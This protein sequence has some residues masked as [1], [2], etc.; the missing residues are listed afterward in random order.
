MNQAEIKTMVA[1]HE[2]GHAYAAYVLQIP[3]KSI[4]LH[5]QDGPGDFGS[6]V[7]NPG[8]AFSI[9]EGNLAERERAEKLIICLLSGPAAEAKY[10]GASPWLGGGTDLPQA[11]QLACRR[12]A[13]GT[14]L[15]LKREIERLWQCARD[16]ICS[17]EGWECV[18]RLATVLEQFGTLDA[19]LCGR[20][21]R[22]WQ[23]QLRNK[24]QHTEVTKIMDENDY[25]RIESD[26]AATF[27]R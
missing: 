11:I 8:E 19:V 2:A 23:K 14:E 7:L 13:Y 10:I 17:T 18:R 25:G 24:N 15:E 5:I 1:I 22:D 6:L 20:I 12:F 27:V 26:F 21:I 4:K 3:F 16:L 9:D